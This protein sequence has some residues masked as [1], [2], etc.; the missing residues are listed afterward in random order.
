MK[1][2]MMKTMIRLMMLI[3]A[4][5]IFTSCSKVPAGNVGVKVYLLGGA[6][7]VD[8]EELGVGRYYIGINEE[9]FLFPTFTQNYVWT[10]NISEG[11]ENDESITFQTAE[12]MPVNADVGISYHINPK[13]VSA[14]FQKYRKGI[15]EITDIFMRNMVRDAFNK[16]SST[17]KIES[18]YGVGKV[19]LLKEI[20]SEI[21][22]QCEPI[23]II[24]EKIYLI[25]NLRLPP[26]VMKSI[27]A[28][29]E[30][31]QKAQ[32]RENEIQETKAEAQKKIEAARG[33]A[34]SITIQAKAQANANILLSRSIT[35]TLVEYESIKKWNGILPK[36]TGG[37]A[38]PFI[39][40]NT[41]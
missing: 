2:K 22:R 11:S 29:I 24:V 35:P 15:E 10:K 9:L 30:A 34:E 13:M 39:N 41:D 23:G 38:V 6:K 32:M 4:C 18:V 28:K 1:K 7:G 33:I 14:V 12:G 16:A 27:D 40:V 25:G 26:A 3:M 17:K 5:F 31:T 19:A 21:S 8:M 37:G 36:F 20:E